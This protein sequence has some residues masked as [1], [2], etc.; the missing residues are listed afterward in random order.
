APPD[1]PLKAEAVLKDTVASLRTRGYRFDTSLSAGAQAML[2]P[3]TQRTGTEWRVGFQ[4]FYTI[5]RYNRSLLYA[6]AV[7]DL[8][9]AIEQRSR[10]AGSPRVPGTPAPT[11]A[12][13]AP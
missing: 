12:P 13:A 2:V 5:T 10:D 9:A 1:D 7:N 4:N 8:A 11:T 3:A 6:M